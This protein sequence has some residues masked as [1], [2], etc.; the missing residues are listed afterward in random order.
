M[1]K[2]L[3]FALGVI[4]LPTTLA[5]AGGYDIVIKSGIIQSTKSNGAYWD[6]LKGA[7]DPYVKGGIQVERNTLKNVC[8]TKVDYDT[9][10][11][12]WNQK[13][14]TVS[15]GDDVV[16][17]V[18]DKDLLKDDAI[19]EYKFTVTKKMVADGEV[20]VKFGRVKELRFVLKAAG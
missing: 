5:V 18:W 17:Q 12:D 16:L 7:P 8:K 4:V 2:I 14:C 9:Y 13:L 10:R 19:G 20:R 1:Y 11:P 3:V 15:I 6:G